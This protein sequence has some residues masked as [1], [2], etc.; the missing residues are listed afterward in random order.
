[1]YLPIPSIDLML[2]KTAFFLIYLLVCFFMMEAMVRIAGSVS[3]RIAYEIRPPWGN[4]DVMEDPV[5]GYRLSPYFLESDNRGFRNK[6][7]MEQADILA[8]G[9][10]M[11]Y[12]ATVG[13]DY[14]WPAQLSQLAGQSVYNGGIGGYGPCEYLE[15]ARELSELNAK[16]I[17]FGLY[18]GNDMSGAY[19]SVYLERRCDELRSEDSLVLDKVA[20]A[21][22]ESSLRN[23]ALGLGMDDVPH[24]FVQGLPDND[25]IKDYVSFKD[26]SALYRAIRQVYYKLKK[27]RW[28]RFGDGQGKE[29]FE[30][31]KKRFG[32]VA[33]DQVPELRTVFQ[34]PDIEILASDQTDIRIEEGRRMTE[35][36]MTKFQEMTSESG[37]NLLVVLIP[38]KSLVYSSVLEPFSSELPENLFEQIRLDRILRKDITEFLQSQQINYIDVTDKFVEMISNKQ[39]P[40]YEVPNE[41]PNVE[42]YK[43]I[44]DSVAKFLSQ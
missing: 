12:G 16:T 43:I 24:P 37:A 20:Q 6:T 34:N 8:V 44:A 23:K 35:L 3:P 18:L 21:N 32:A 29:T 31:S 41:H 5:L 7:D 27:V 38:P 28:Y 15:V 22:A 4:R 40:Y 10:S 13:M 39:N 2:K 26:H 42:G 19:K 14:S 36:T 33:F 17:V 30:E 1:M 9:D 25:Y 11:T